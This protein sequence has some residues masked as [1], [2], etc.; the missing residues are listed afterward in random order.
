M[1]VDSSAPRKD[2]TTVYAITCFVLGAPGRDW[3]SLSSQD[4]KNAI[5]SE[6]KTLYQRY[7]TSNGDEH[8]VVGC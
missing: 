1:T 4:R 5:T 6:L 7:M 2:G 8:F 3:A